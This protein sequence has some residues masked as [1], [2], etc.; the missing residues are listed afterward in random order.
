MDGFDVEVEQNRKLGL[1]AEVL[2]TTGLKPGDR[3]QIQPRRDGRLVIVRTS[4]LLDRYSGAVPG[5]S[6]ATDLAESHEE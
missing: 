1:P 4:S 3:A 5:L 6:A 2:A